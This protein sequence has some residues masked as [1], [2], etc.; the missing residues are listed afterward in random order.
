MPYVK[1]PKVL[2]PEEMIKELAKG[3]Q[4]Q[5]VT[6]NMHAYQPHRKQNLFHRSNKKVRLYIGGNRSGKTVGGVIED[7]WWATG[8]HPYL[9]VPTPCHGR[10]VSVDF[11]NGVEKIIF[12]IFKRWLIPSDLRGGTWDAAY[13]KVERVLHFAN[14]S[15]IEF[16]SYDQDLD[17][18]AGTSRHFIHFDEEPPKHIYIENLLRT[19]DVGG[20]LWLTM[21]PLDGM[22]WVYEDLYEVASETDHETI[23]VVEVNIHE[24]P[25]LPPEE[26]ATVLG[27][28]DDDERKAREQ[29]KF[30]QLGGLVYKQF[31]EDNNVFVSDYA[32]PWLPPTDGSW[33]VF[34]SLDHGFNNPTAWLWHAVNE[35]GDCITFWEHYASEMT[36][37]QHAAKVLEVNKRFKLNPSIYVGDPSIRNR[38]P[39]TGTSIHEEYIKHGVP[40]VLGNNDVNAGII[41]V[42]KYIR[43]KGSNGRAKWTV[44]SCCVNLIKELKRYRWAVYSNKTLQ[45]QN[46]PQEKPHKKDDHACDSLRYF[47]MMRPDIVAEGFDKPAPITDPG[48]IDAARNL[49]RNN[50][51][52]IVVQTRP[53]DNWT[54]DYAGLD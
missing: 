16:M 6:P 53:K 18:F 33:D 8:R 5:A 37:D 3:L 43:T 46:N 7:L 20:R 1:K 27:F 24:N 19:T 26:V 9:N 49:P 31:S 41:R 38:D 25:Y 11:V 17:K 40:I 12:P 14:E 34:C 45:Y 44:G 32:D 4:T 13:D 51:G 47:I 54:Y 29:G 48:I 21:T 22:T 50:E 28:L 2:T 36:V 35:E 30:V 42:A 10:V 39:L 15:F 23:D 52:D